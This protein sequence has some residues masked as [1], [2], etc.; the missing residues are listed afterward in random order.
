MFGGN[1]FGWP[2]FGQ[3]YAGVTS[4]DVTISAPAAAA[5]AVAPPPSIPGPTP[6]TPAGSGGTSE[7]IP[8][9]HVANVRLRVPPM[10]AH[11]YFPA[12]AVDVEDTVAPIVEEEDAFF[13]ELLMLEFV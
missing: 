2:Y 11:A 13:E 5:D 10:I 3:A 9:R 6:P 8:G 4:G 12:C 7:R 1:A